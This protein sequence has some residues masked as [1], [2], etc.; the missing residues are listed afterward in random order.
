MADE[1]ISDPGEV[2]GVVASE[3]RFDI[4]ESLWTARHEDDGGSTDDGVGFAALRRRTDIDDSGQ[5]NYHLDKLSPRF[6][7]KHGGDYELT[8]AGESVVAAAV[9]GMYTDLDT[10]LAA[11][12]V[13]DCPNCGGP[14]EAAYREGRVSVECVDCDLLVAAATVPPVAVT[15]AEAA[16]LPE[17]Y[18]RYVVSEIYRMNSGF[19]TDCGG[20]LDRRLERDAGRDPD[21][22]FTDELAAHYECR[23]CGNQSQGVVMMAALDDPALV[24]FLHEAGIDLREEPP[25]ELDWLF[26][27]LGTVAS[28]DPLRVEITVELDDRALTLTLD[29]SL[30]AVD[31]DRHDPSSDGEG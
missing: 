4:L 13:T 20:R 19:C 22:P 2:F 17:L 28:E 24:S 8:A 14:V 26:E 6:V 15:D 27:S 5:F 23:A 25:W 11:H 16:E 1:G 31:A 10:E 7:R 18:N 30:D 9:S 3:A 21:D 29:E 12:R